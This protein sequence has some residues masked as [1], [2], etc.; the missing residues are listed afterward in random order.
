LGEG[1]N[2]RGGR[3]G[4]G[5]GN[6]HYKGPSGTSRKITGHKEMRVDGR[7]M[8]RKGKFKGEK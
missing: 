4:E 1:T 6:G 8:I 2:R 5:K 3:V 7:K